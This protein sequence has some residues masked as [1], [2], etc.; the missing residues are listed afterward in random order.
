M[1]DAQEGDSFLDTILRTRV[2]VDPSRS[3]VNF[4]EES[5]EDAKEKEEE[6]GEEEDDDEGQ[7][8]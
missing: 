7:Q 2:R 1:D 8:K 5:N 3:R 4:V 6:D